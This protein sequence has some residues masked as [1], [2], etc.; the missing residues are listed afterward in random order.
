MQSQKKREKQTNKH[1]SITTNSNN[2]EIIGINKY[3]SLISFSINGLDSPVKD[4]D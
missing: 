3:Y 4:T 2:N 1:H